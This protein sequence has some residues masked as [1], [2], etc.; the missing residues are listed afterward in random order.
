NFMGF[1]KPL[2]YWKWSDYQD[3]ISNDAYP[4]PSS[5]GSITD[6]AMVCDLMRSLAKG[7][8]W[9]LMEQV[10]SQVNW[11]PQNVLKRPG[12]MRLWSYQAMARGANGL[13]FFQW[14][15]SKAGAEKFHGAL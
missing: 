5:S 3:I 9:L 12:Q 7:K 4:D 8:S 15:A 14:R 11:R 1:F 2:D 10:T 13:M 6:A